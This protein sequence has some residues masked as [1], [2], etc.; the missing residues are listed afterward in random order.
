V[1][2]VQLRIAELTRRHRQLSSAP[3][4]RSRIQRHDRRLPVRGRSVKT[5]HAG[6]ERAVATP[7]PS[8]R[9]ML[10]R[11]LCSN[12]DIPLTPYDVL[13]LKKNA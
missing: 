10:E 2:F 13:R 12:I 8:Q 4:G 6:G 11:L 1:Y 3:H 5:H 9:Q 7:L